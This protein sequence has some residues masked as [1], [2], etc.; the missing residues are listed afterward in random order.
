[1]K[2]LA[3][4][5]LLAALGLGLHAQVGLYGIF[6]DATLAEADS[7]LNA[8]GFAV[9]NLN[10]GNLVSYYPLN[11]P[12]TD[13]VTLVMNPETKTVAGWLVQYNAANTEAE[14]NYVFFQ[15]NKM[16]ND[17]FK[18][19]EETD[20]FVWFLN[21]TRTVHLVYRDNGAMTVLYYDSNYDP[22]FGTGKKKEK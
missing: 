14:D 6:Y 20:Q 5:L 9:G 1:M 21:D 18:E 12:K 19:Y 7:I 22:L 15:L 8:E 2:R 11:N 10:T 16:H 17:W 4:V 13:V 3:L